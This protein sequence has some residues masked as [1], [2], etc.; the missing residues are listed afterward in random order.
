MTIYT[1]LDDRWDV[2][3]GPIH[4]DSPVIV[5]DR[6]GYT[7]CAGG[8]FGACGHEAGVVISAE[9]ALGQADEDSVCRVGNIVAPARWYLPRGRGVGRAIR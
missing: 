2:A 6:N 5:A 7:W 3:S 9:L 4:R 8:R 1:R